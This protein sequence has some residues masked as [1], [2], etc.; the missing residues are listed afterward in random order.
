MTILQAVLLGIV[1]GIT[2]FLPISSSGHL[3]LVPWILGW[4]FDLQTAFVFDVLVQWGTTLAVILYF[5]KDLWHMFLEA[6]RNLL[7]G[8]PFATGKSRLAWFI[9]LASI[10]AAVAGILLKDLV[11]ATFINPLATSLALLF[12]AGLMTW[13]EHGAV[14]R[15]RLFASTWVDALWIGTFQVLALFPG[16]S[17]SGVTISAGLWRNFKRPDAARFSFFMAVPVM[18][19]AGLVALRDLAA[20]PDPG[21]QIGPLVAGALSALI[22]GMLSIHWLLRY[23]ARKPLRVFAIYCTVVGLAGIVIYVLLH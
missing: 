3:V 22:V 13:A 18:F 19:G 4:D 20:M 17:R 16:I 2:E 5:R 9:L 15:K 7:R 21:A 14:L 8:T 6:T 11:A 12:T 1:Q 10:P 23:L